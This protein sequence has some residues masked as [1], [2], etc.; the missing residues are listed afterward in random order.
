MI[1]FVVRSFVIALTPVGR[2]TALASGKHPR[3]SRGPPHNGRTKSP[4]REAS[5]YWSGKRAPCLAAG[6]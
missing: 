6:G 3:P 4:D 2:L 1:D 5:Y